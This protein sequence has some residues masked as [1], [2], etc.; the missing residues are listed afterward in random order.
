MT[1]ADL[2]DRKRGKEFR[3]AAEHERTTGKPLLT[4]DRVEQWHERAALIPD[5][6]EQAVK[7]KIDK[8]YSTAAARQLRL[9]I[10][11]QIHEWDIAQREVEECMAERTSMA[12]NVFGEVWIIWKTKLY[13]VWAGGQAV[14][15]VVPMDV[16]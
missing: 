7:L 14:M 9:V 15:E 2:P 6:I 13:R 1:E 4:E 11:L 16:G 3:E 5:A 10:L 12:K 8:R